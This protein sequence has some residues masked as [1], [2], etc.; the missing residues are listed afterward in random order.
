[1]LLSL[2][3]ERSVVSTDDR[4]GAEDIGL[5]GHGDR[6]DALHHRHWGGHCDGDRWEGV[7]AATFRDRLKGWQEGCH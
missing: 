1:M 7:P 4:G 3:A 6:S 5:G 2:G